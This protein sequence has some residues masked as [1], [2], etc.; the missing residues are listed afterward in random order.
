MTTRRQR[1]RAGAVAF[2][3]AVAAVLACGASAC[4]HKAAPK[5]NTALFLT[6]SH[7]TAAGATVPRT[8]AELLGLGR[9]ACADLD[10]GLRTDQ[11][12]ADLSGNAEPGSAAFNEQAYIAAT[13]TRTLCSR[14]EK[15]FSGSLPGLDG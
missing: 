3:A 2:A 14:H 11:V 8:D 7:A 9:R 10:K 6:L 15:D 13:A 12:V 4:G 5:E 1:S